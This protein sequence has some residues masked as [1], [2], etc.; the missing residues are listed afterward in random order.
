LENLF[1]LNN[2][3]AT[4]P[5][6]VDLISRHRINTGGAKVAFVLRS[7]RV[8]ALHAIVD[9]LLNTPGLNGLADAGVADKRNPHGGSA[10][11]GAKCVLAKSSL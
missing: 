4:V 5:V 6:V 10:R 3:L 9:V 8:L 7:I 2:G 11:F 1:E